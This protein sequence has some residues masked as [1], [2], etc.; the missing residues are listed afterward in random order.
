MFSGKVPFHGVQDTVV[1]VNVIAKDER[2]L[3][4]AHSQL[5]D[6]L[7]EMIQKCWRREPSERPTIQEVVTFLEK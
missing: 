7:W 2:P 5:S 1:V 4:P 3:R 6:P